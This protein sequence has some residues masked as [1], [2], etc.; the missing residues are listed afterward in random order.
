MVLPY[1]NMNQPQVYMCSPSWTPLPSPS[2]SHPSGSSQ[3][4]RPEFFQ[5]K[6]L[7]LH[8]VLKQAMTLN[9]PTDYSLLNSILEDKLEFRRGKVIFLVHTARLELRLSRTVVW[10]LLAKL[11][12]CIFPVCHDSPD[13][14]PSASEIHMLEWGPGLPKQLR[15]Y[16]ETRPQA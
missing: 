2:P 6:N 1:I 12:G 16:R 13:T 15:V 3:C 14:V 10:T 4:T 5:K 9:W 8:I 7:S 11:S